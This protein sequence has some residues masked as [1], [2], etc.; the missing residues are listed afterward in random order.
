MKFKSILLLIVALSLLLCS[1]NDTTFTTEPESAPAPSAS[2]STSSEE[3]P[4]NPVLAREVFDRLRE[5]YRN[6]FATGN[7][8][9]LSGLNNTLEKLKGSE[10]AEDPMWAPGWRCFWAYD[11]INDPSFLSRE[12]A[13]QIETGLLINEVY[14]LIGRPHYNTAF[15]GYKGTDAFMTFID[16]FKNFDVYT[17]HVLEDGEVLL[18]GYSQVVAEKYDSEEL[19]E[20]IGEEFAYVFLSEG[21]VDWRVLTSIQIL[22]IEELADMGMG[23]WDFEYSTAE[24]FRS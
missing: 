22:D 18:L 10:K 23:R 3:Y 15:D 9:S 11:N 6:R 14:E 7:R 12:K 1:C 5:N 20:R 24:E 2:G 4:P 17:M 16:Y 19:R 13:E 21:G 8:Y